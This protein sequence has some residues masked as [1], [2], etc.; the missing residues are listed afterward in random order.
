MS[1]FQ[2]SPTMAT[3]LAF[4][5]RDHQHPVNHTLHRIFIP[6]IVFSSAGFLAQVPWHRTL[7]GVPLGFPEAALA[8][9][10]A[11]YAAHDLKLAFLAVPFA[12]LMAVG[13]RALPWP[14]HLGIFVV[15]WVAQ[16]IGHA[17]FEHNRPSLTANLMALLIAPA[18]LLDELLPKPVEQD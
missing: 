13:A 9:L 14:A 15:S 1:L 7:Y 6:L 8:L 4:Y 10:I 3:W 17:R 11:F 18:F 12:G 5:A 16:L 2:R